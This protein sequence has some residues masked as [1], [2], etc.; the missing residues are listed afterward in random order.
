MEQIILILN[1]L[2][3]AGLAYFLHSVFSGL[4][5]RIDTLQTT[6]NEQK[7]TLNAVRERADE[8]NRLSKGYKQA[9]EDFEAMGQKLETRRKEVVDE[10]EEANQ[11]K[12]QK[13]IEFRELEIK[14]IELKKQSLEAIP[15]IEARLKEVVS[16]LES[17]IEILDQPKSH[18]IGSTNPYIAA[19]AGKYTAPMSLTSMALLRA[20][21]ASKVQGAEKD[22]STESIIDESKK[23]NDGS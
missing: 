8:F 22:S 3:L 6:V 4:K 5:K 1:S 2:G 11:R 23:Q 7:E 21:S 20:L 17:R 18:I 14:E 16:E 13:L 19:L 15:G 9:L 10:L 12:D